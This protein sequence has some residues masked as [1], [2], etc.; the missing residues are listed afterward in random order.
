MVLNIR[1]KYN[2]G[3]SLPEL[4]VTIALVT[5]ITAVV[6]FRYGSFNSSTLL[7]SQ[8]YEVGLDIRQT[9]VYGLSVRSDGSTNWREEYGL[10]F[11]N[12]DNQYIFFQDS[13]SGTGPAQYNAGEEINTI[14]LDSRFEISDIC[15]DSSCDSGGTS[16]SNVSITFRRPNFNA[17]F[18]SPDDSSI[19]T[20][21]IEVSPVGSTEVRTVSVTNTGQITSY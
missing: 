19:S 5:I 9:Q 4:V 18:H 17:L 15:S 3:F 7:K 20:V 14:R 8:A 10:Y 11:V 1:N 21:Y 13:G 6:L 12:G 16:L 2:G